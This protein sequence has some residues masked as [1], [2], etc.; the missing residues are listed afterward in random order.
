[1]TCPFC[2]PMVEGAI[3]AHSEKFLA[4][5]NIA[6][7][8]P[9]HSL[10]IPKRHL[11]S[12]MELNDSELSEMIIFTKKVTDLLLTAFSAEA[13]NWSLQEKEFAG[14]SV[15]HLHLH[16]VPRY[17][18]DLPKPGD[19]YPKLKTNHEKILDSETRQKLSYDE[20]EQIINRLRILSEEKQ[21][22][23]PG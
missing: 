6:P 14:Q 21:L 4:I 19:W 13:F 15:A 12:I 5:Y 23:S 10:V 16:I 7:I 8:L 2:N 9:G 1:M 20:M 3:F 11:Q 17:K 18:D 22:F